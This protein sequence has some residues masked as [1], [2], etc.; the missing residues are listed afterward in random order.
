M[1]FE[2]K[3]DLL[4]SWLETIEAEIGAGSTAWW[5]LTQNLDRSDLRRVMHRI[6]S[7]YRPHLHLMAAVYDAALFDRALDLGLQ[8]IVERTADGLR[9]HIERGQREG[10]IDLDLL[11]AETAS[12]LAW[13][14]LRGQR[15]LR[16]AD[17]AEFERE[18]D[19]YTDV[20][21]NVLYAPG[22]PAFHQ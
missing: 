13:L 4:H 18:I 22:R 10:W 11:A 19:A 9:H 6:L 2:D 15:R 17:D 20:L 5:E 3:A 7:A 14:V 21:W 1:Y 12:W 16:S 8:A